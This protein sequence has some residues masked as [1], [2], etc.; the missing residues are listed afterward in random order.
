[1][2]KVD[3]KKKLKYL[4]RSSVRQFAAPGIYLAETD[5]SLRLRAIDLLEDLTVADNH[6]IKSRGRSCWTG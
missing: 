4:Y 2:E 3:L 1:M 6:P 5:T